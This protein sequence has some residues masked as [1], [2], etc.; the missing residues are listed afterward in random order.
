M[1][2]CLSTCTGIHSDR[3]ISSSINRFAKSVNL[4]LSD[5]PAG[6]DPFDITLPVSVEAVRDR[7]LT[8]GDETRQAL[9]NRA[10]QSLLDR[11]NDNLDEVVKA[12]GKDIF[13]ATL[14]D[15]Y[16]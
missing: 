8:R 11:P 4:K 2:A 3:R 9:F 1:G 5:V 7:M 14:H 16:R 15:L 12:H 10:K 13:R 6:I